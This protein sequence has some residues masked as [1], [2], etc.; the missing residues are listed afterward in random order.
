MITVIKFLKKGQHTVPYRC[1]LR[2]LKTD[3]DMAQHLEL[4]VLEIPRVLKWGC[5][6]L[7]ENGKQAQEHIPTKV[8]L[9]MLQNFQINVLFYTQWETLV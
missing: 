3:L 7:L 5:S 9:Y 1:N 4:M 6:K 2:T 8:Y